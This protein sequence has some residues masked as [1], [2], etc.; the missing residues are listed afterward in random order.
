M[1]VMSK[2]GLGKTQHIKRKR[3]RPGLILFH[4]FCCYQLWVHRQTL[5]PCRV[6]GGAGQGGA[7]AG[8][9]AWAGD[10]ALVQPPGQALAPPAPACRFSWAGVYACL[11]R[12]N[13]SLTKYTVS[14]AFPPFHCV[15]CVS[16]HLPLGMPVK[17]KVLHGSLLGGQLRVH[18]PSYTSMCTRVLNKQ[19]WGV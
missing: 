3:E 8:P 4:S 10:A 7:R 5:E 1:H 18:L 12:I 14:G 2:R 6:V 16:V 17:W 15:L 19:S 11:L 9:G 13:S